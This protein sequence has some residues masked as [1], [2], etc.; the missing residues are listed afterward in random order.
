MLMVEVYPVRASSAISSR[1]ADD[2]APRTLRLFAKLEAPKPFSLRR[3]GG[4]RHSSRP[5]ADVAAPVRQP[6]F[7]FTS[8]HTKEQPPHVVSRNVRFRSIATAL[9]RSR[10]QT[11]PRAAGSARGD[12]RPR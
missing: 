8:D 11:H 2:G 5:N 4:S 3:T 7:P 10:V 12:L 6:R 1:R 9:F